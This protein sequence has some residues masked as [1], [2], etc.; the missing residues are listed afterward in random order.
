MKPE[1]LI[2]KLEDLLKE[3]NQ[4]RVKWIVEMKTSE[5]DDTVDKTIVHENGNDWI[6]NECY[7]C[8]SCNFHGEN[9]VMITYE[10]FETCNDLTRS[11]NMVFIP[12]T[13]IHLFDIEYLLPYSIKM[14]SN[15]AKKLHVLWDTLLSLY[16]SNSEKVT[17]IRQEWDSSD[18]THHIATE[19]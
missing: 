6:M 15:L 8:Y 16:K 18:S 17:F 5:Y 9:F 14:N 1:A 19:N 13:G 3:T 10:D 4:N 2:A 11:L 7:V 12:T